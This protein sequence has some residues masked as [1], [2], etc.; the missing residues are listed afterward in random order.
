MGLMSGIGMI[1]ASLLLI[2]EPG[3]SG[4]S[5]RREIR[6]CGEGFGERRRSL[7]AD[8]LPWRKPQDAT[9]LV[10]GLSWLLLSLGL[11]IG[12]HPTSFLCR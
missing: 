11:H 1:A 2:K 10:P 7:E 12:V 6:A 8:I 4:I 5:L 3:D 9:V